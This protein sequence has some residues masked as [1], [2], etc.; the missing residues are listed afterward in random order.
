MR[1]LLV[2]HGNAHAGL[3]G[4]IA[5]PSGCR[6]LTDLGRSEAER[7]R[8][9]WDRRG[10]DADVLVASELRRAIETAAIVAPGLGIEDVPQDCDLCEVH[11]GEADGRDWAEF[12]AD[13]GSFDMSAEPD[14]L[15]APGGDSWRTFHERV[16]GA[17]DRLA[18]AHAGRVVVAVT[19][20]GWIA[21]S[22]RVHLGRD[23]WVPDVRLQ[24]TNT[25]VTEWEHDGATGT[26]RLH[27]YDE[28]SHLV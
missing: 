11:V 6:G 15:F 5:G 2:R 13:H 8:D 21:A 3:T 18:D 1:L 16:A 19:H 12:V 22:L 27:R 7:L 20:A 25:G 10:F 23:P 26:W 9:H 17:M 14:R 24:P 28:V 4:T